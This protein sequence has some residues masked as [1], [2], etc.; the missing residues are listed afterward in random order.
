MT[1][2][3]KCGAAHLSTWVR[4][5]EPISSYVCD[6]CQRKVDKVKGTPWHGVAQLCQDCLF[7]WYDPDNDTFDHCNP[8]E[9]GNYVR[10]KHGLPPLGDQ[11]TS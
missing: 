6:C 11:G 7:Q 4:R 3:P 1:W 9:L 2:C 10:K 5:C 8:I